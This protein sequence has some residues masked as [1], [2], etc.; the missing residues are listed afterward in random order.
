MNK[1]DIVYY[2]DDNE[3]KKGVLVESN[4]NHVLLEDRRF[5]WPGSIFK[6]P[7]ELADDLLN[8]FNSKHTIKSELQESK[9]ALCV[10]CGKDTGIVPETCCSGR[11][12]GCMGMPVNGPFVCSEHC[13]NKKY[14]N[15]DESRGTD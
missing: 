1:G 15:T 3:I 13:Y 2:I 14:G 10:V 11:E 4:S 5:L 12:C 7:N 8:R 6:T 9:T